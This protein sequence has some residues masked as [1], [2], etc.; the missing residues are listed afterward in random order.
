MWKNHILRL[1]SVTDNIQINSWYILKS[2]GLLWLC[3][4][5]VTKLHSN[6]T[7]SLKEVG[8]ALNNSYPWFVEQQRSHINSYPR[9]LE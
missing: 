7:S 6:P 1:G 2:C 9:F 8:F 5:L 3:Y 4:G